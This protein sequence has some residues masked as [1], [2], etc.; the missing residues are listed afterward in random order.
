MALLHGVF[1]AACLAEAY[2]RKPAVDAL[3]YVGIAILIGAMVCL[4]HVIRTLGPIWTVK[5][6]IAETHPLNRSPL[7]R[8][9]KH[10][11]YY[12]NIVPELIGLSLVCGAW[13][14][15][16]T[17]LPLYLI[18]LIVRIRQEEKAMQARFTDY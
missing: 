14:S 12:L 10:P 6:F 9:A 15:V 7:F 2:V 17:I 4:F 8:W 11:N 3:T 18:S 1:Y 13:L 5:V 16:V